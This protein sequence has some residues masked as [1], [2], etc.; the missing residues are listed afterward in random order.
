MM[1]TD[2]YKRFI[3]LGGPT[4]K[5][6]RFIDMESGRITISFVFIVGIGSK[7]D[8]LLLHLLLFF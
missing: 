7:I 4:V 3:T 2:E 1:R 8:S 6:N 5:T